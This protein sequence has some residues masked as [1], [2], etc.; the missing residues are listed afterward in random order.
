[1]RGEKVPRWETELWSYVGRGNGKSCPLYDECHVHNETGYCLSAYQNR[2][3]R[4]LESK[5]FN[6]RDYALIKCKIYCKMYVLIEKLALKYFEKGQVHYPPIL[7][8]IISLISGQQNIEIRLVSLKAHHGAIWQLRDGWVIHVNANDTEEKRRFTIF[9]EAFHILAHC[10]ASPVFHKRGSM[11]GAFSEIMADCFASC[12][13]MPEACM[14]K[15]W[16]EVK[17]LDRMAEIFWVPM[18]EM[19][20]R[21][22]RLGLY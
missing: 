2:T 20:V 1:M 16:A 18:P 13:L 8:D 5:R 4:L 7:T 3:S 12:M 22:K 17:D 9:H 15:M 10:Q 21:L 19:C 14:R 6:L 11:G